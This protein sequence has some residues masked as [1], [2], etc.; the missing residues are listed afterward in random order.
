M[1]GRGDDLGCDLGDGESFGDSC[2]DIDGGSSDLDLSDIVG[3]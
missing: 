1:E 3:D 2:R